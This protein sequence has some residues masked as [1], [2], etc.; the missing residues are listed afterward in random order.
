MNNNLNKYNKAFTL[1]ELLVVIAIVGLLASVVLVSLDDAKD[2]AKI[3]KTLSWAGSIHSSMAID[4]VGEWK[5]NEG[6]TLKGTNAND[7][8]TVNDSSGNENAGTIRGNPVWRN[9]VNGYSALEFDGVSDYIDINKNIFDSQ[10]FTVILWAKRNDT[11]SNCL[12]R[13]EKPGGS[14][15]RIVV[16]LDASSMNY[17]RNNGAYIGIVPSPIGSV[18]VWSHYAFVESTDGCKVY[19]NGEEIGS[20]N[21]PLGIN[22]GHFREIGRDYPF[23]GFIDEVRVYSEALSA[24]EIKQNYLAGVDTHQNLAQR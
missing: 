19:L 24:K 13:I 3:A 9:G 17:Y 20:S 4:C 12:Y 22:M 7:G 11:S 21:T 15:E 1:I 16:V 10:N 8:D 2:R 6:V 18:D 5:F 14:G 23:N